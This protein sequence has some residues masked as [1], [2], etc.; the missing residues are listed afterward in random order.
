MRWPAAAPLRATQ[1]LLAGISRA[2]QIALQQ[3]SKSST[4]RNNYALTISWICGTQCSR[5][6]NYI[7]GIAAVAASDLMIL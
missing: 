4:S 6:I 3:V 7:H 2:F 5:A 1:S